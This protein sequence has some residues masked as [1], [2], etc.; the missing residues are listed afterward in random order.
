M[1]TPWAG[2]GSLPRWRS[3]CWAGVIEEIPG[4]DRRK[5]GSLEQT[6]MTPK[7]RSL[8]RPSCLLSLGKE[9]GVKCVPLALFSDSL[10]L[11]VGSCILRVQ[12]S[13]T[14]RVVMCIS[15]LHPQLPDHPEM[16]VDPEFHP[17]CSLRPRVPLM[18]RWVCKAGLG[19]W[20]R[21]CGARA[22]PP[23][24]ASLS[25]QPSEPEPSPS[26]LIYRNMQRWK[27]IRQR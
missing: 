27:R 25:M 15:C 24:L 26:T 5:Q 3:V 4:L 16:P 8:V 1:G 21:S 12:R 9:G 20:G 17:H 19:Q 7:Y 23:S 11:G 6:D 14:A 22:W 18:M 2:N 10:G 13:P